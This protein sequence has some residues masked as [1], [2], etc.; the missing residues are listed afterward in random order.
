MLDSLAAFIQFLGV[1]KR[2]GKKK[3]RKGVD[4]DRRDY[5]MK[6]TVT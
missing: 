1:R 6:V 2:A 3:E 4:V 5:V